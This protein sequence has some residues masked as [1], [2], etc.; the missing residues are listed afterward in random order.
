MN[1][2]TYSQV[3]AME[4]K[5]EK[6]VIEKGKKKIQNHIDKVKA[7]MNKMAKAIVRR[8]EDHDKS[9]FNEPE[10]T[11]MTKYLDD[12]KETKYNS[13]EHKELMKKIE[14]AR[15]HHYKENSHHPEH[16]KNGIKGMD[17]LDLFEMVCD[18]KVASEQNN[19]DGSIE[20]S[21]KE[22]QKRFSYGDELKQILLN[23]AKFLEGGK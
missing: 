11:L 17:L 19:K 1:I 6:E 4:E 16:Y 20:Q 8:G 5:S 3:R 7:L 21:I 12:M 22:N 10:L 9:K 15:E 2:R 13:P 18:W 14:P 23:T